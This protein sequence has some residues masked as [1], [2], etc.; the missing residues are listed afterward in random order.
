MSI[1]RCLNPRIIWDVIWIYSDL[2][3]NI[4]AFVRRRGWGCPWPP[5]PR[6]RQFQVSKPSSCSHKR[7]ADALQKEPLSTSIHYSHLYIHYH[8]C[9]FVVISVTSL[10]SLPTSPHSIHNIPQSTSMTPLTAQ[11]MEAVK[12][13]EPVLFWAEQPQPIRAIPTFC[14]STSFHG[15]IDVCLCAFISHYSCVV[16]LQVLTRN[17][18]LLPVVSI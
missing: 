3:S 11:E 7:H 10:F 8:V 13:Q 9:G 1:L 2:F 14:V 4:Y 6:S 5:P 17:L 16:Y 15:R 18:W 12:L